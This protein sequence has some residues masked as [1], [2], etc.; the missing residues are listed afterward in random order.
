MESWDHQ[1][2]TAN[3]SVTLEERCGRGLYWQQNRAHGSMNFGSFLTKVGIW[4]YISHPICLIRGPHILQGW[5]SLG[6]LT[7]FELVLHFGK[8]AVLNEYALGKRAGDCILVSSYMFSIHHPHQQFCWLVE[9]YSFTLTGC[10]RG[11][12]IEGWWGVGGSCFCIWVELQ[13]CCIFLHL[14]CVDLTFSIFAL[15]GWT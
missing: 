1:S 14:L 9:K 6:S 13:G 10:F 4:I 12:S 2:I 8:V 11:G 15:F 3:R 5:G 7:C